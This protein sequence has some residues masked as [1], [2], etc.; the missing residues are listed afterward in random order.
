MK[1]LIIAGVAVSAVL[2]G[3]NAN[4]VPVPLRANGTPDTAAAFAAG[5]AETFMTGSSAAT[6]FITAALRNGNCA[7]GAPI[8]RYVDSTNGSF[9]F[10]CEKSAGFAA[11]AAPY[12]LMHK[13]DGGGSLNGV[14]HADPSLPE[15][16]SQVFIVDADLVNVTSCAAVNS[17]GVSN[18]SGGVVTANNARGRVSE[19]G[20]SDVDPAQF[21]SNINGSA[22]LGN[23]V[24][25]T[26]IA[27]QV[28]GIAVNT[29]LRDAMQGAM[30]A[31]SVLPASCL[32][33]NGIG[34]AAVAGSRESEECMP[35]LTRAQLASIF[36]RTRVTDW[37]QFA[38]GTTLANQR[39]FTTN[40]AVLPAADRPSNR[41]IHICTR[42]QGSG[43]LAT[44][45]IKIE[46]APCVGALAE[47]VLAATSQTIGTET[48][49]SGSLKVVHS[50]SGSGDVESCLSALNSGA[51]VGTFTPYPVTGFRW[52][53]GIQ[54]I[55]RNT[56]GSIPYRFIKIDNVS[57]SA[58]NVSEGRYHFWAE[59]VAVSATGTITNDPLASAIVATM[60]NPATI[61]SFLNVTH[62]WG[63]VTGFLGV[64]TSTAF[65]PT[66]TA[67]IAPGTLLN[68]AFDAA[69]PV[70]PYSHVA[71]SGGDLN[72]CRLPTIPSGQGRAIPA[73]YP[74][75]R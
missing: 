21:A 51:A 59:L 71:A 40:V 32:T 31:A 6:P 75:Y 7:A 57:P 2:A 73:F 5:V 67:V 30:V 26:P 9:A 72:H 44:A 36:A 63:G 3:M 54:G 42:T 37:A 4:A 39:L 53:I 43:T 12:L 74:V 27:T 38:Y 22:I 55:E 49:A 68:A 33:T 52:A 62:T 23:A 16:S 20:F 46:D 70:N 34:A 41:D 14:R 60:S 29:R 35:N 18:C 56:N 64:A 13:R 28:F 10:L 66:S 48:G 1:K 17:A 69:R 58:H 24:V 25:S 61:G 19:A 45:Q 47:P 50:M 15:S 11:V 8:Y 65:P